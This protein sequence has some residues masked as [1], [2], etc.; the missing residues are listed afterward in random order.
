MAKGIGNI[1]VLP[2][3]GLNC[4]LFASAPWAG[5]SKIEVIM[6]EDFMQVSYLC[7]CLSH[8]KKG[9]RPYKFDLLLPLL[10]NSIHQLALARN[11]QGIENS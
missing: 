7:T 1:E 11:T 4:K 9:C 10:S 2:L 6:P 8:D 5:L 3:G